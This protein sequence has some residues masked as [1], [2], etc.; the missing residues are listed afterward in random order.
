MA[1]AELFE[2]LEETEAADAC[3]WRIQRIDE[4]GLIHHHH[5][6]LSWA[7]YDLFAPGGTTPPAQVA[8]AV[9]RFMLDRDEFQPLPERL[10]AALPR[11]RVANAD[12]MISGLIRD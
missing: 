7:D 6:R 5:L 4:E 8:E 2:L 10:D 3:V 9:V 1:M 11:R 12:T